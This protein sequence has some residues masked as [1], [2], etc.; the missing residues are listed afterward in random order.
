MVYWRVVKFV[1]NNNICINCFNCWVYCLDVVIF[2]REGKLKGVDYFYCKG[3][4]VC[5]DVCFINFKLLW[6]FEE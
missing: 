3:C 2:L 1:Y 6:M 5:V 4:G